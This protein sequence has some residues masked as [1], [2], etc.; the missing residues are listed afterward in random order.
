MSV[1]FRALSGSLSGK[2]ISP[3]QA[4]AQYE[5]MPEVYKQSVSL[6]VFTAYFSGQLRDTI[7]WHDYE[8]TGDK[9][10]RDQATQFACVRTTFDLDVIDCPIDIY[11]KPNLDM[12]PHPIAV[13]ITKI[14]PMKCLRDGLPEFYFS[15]IIQDE[16]MLFGTN[17]TAYNGV[18]YDD[19]LTRYQNFR[20][21]IPPYD[22][23]NGQGRCRWDLLPLV[24]MFRGLRPENIN[25]PINELGKNSI[26]LELIAKENNI[27]QENAHNSVDDVLATIA[28]AK[29]LR[30]SNQKLYDYI[31]SNRKKHSVASQ[32]TLGQP[33]V[34]AKTVFGGERHFCSPVLPICYSTADKNVIFAID[35]HSTDKTW[36]ELSAEEL[37]ARVYSKKAE[38]E[39]SG[40]QRPPIVQIKIN[41]CPAL[42]PIKTMI[43]AEERLGV[44]LEQV[45]QLC[46]EYNEPNVFGRTASLLL[47]AFGHWG[48][49]DKPELAEQD[50]YGGFLKGSDKELSEMIQISGLD[51]AVKQGLN[52]L[53]PRLAEIFP[54]MIGRNKPKLLDDAQLGQWVNFVKERLT[55]EIPDG[56]GR[57]NLTNYEQALED[58]DMPKEL[59]DEYIEYVNLIKAKLSL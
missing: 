4:L 50:L 17:G 52:F 35:L 29:L 15:Q 11:C 32:V 54:R 1:E 34:H 13:A 5:N 33:L 20:N 57:I 26:K 49:F 8:G 39:E 12:M 9:P 31:F 44:T 22:R 53:D 7:L 59:V 48:K 45:G 25:W 3:E 42:A 36:L 19:E 27:V 41:Q 10:S 37:K 47:E 40:H 21:F 6:D 16:F 56:D 23:E 30:K 24:A 2:S 46:R 38:L 18:K 14:S 55:K 51:H 58:S 28:T 43:G